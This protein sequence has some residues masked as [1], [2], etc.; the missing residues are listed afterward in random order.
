L[1]RL[2]R[3]PQV[4]PIP[5]RT[6][7]SIPPEGEVSKTGSWR[8]YRPILEVKR[9]SRC[10]LCWLYCPEGAVKI[11]PEGK[12]QINLSTCKGCGICA[13]ECPMKLIAMRF[14]GEMKR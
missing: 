2:A 5:P 14:E 1:I 9:C 6:P 8:I 12:P 10:L 3:R 13:K 11:D 4:K 7:L